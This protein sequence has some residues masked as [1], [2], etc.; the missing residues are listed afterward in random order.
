LLYALLL[1]SANDAAA[2]IA[3]AVGGRIEGFAE[4]MNKRAYQMGLE[5]THFTN[6]HGLFDKEHYTS[7]HDLA[8]IASHAL[9]NETLKKIVSTYKITI[10]FGE[11]SENTRFLVNHNK[12]LKLYDG[13]I[14]VKTGFTKA[15]GRCLVSAAERDGLTLIAVTLNA[16]DDWNDHTKMLDCGFAL[17]ECVTIADVGEFTFRLSVVGGKEVFVTLTNK[18]PIRATLPKERTPIKCKIET[19]HRFEFAPIYPMTELG[20][21]N[22]ICNGVTVASSEL[23]SAE[24]AENKKTDKGLLNRISSFFNE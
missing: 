17:Y 4:M 14:G 23:V 10:P 21:V 6:P 19:Y 20:C 22:Y 13:T 12:L 2:A 7:A 3:I 5:N 8:L 1:R 9:K 11:S 18:K 16:P 24:F 15:T